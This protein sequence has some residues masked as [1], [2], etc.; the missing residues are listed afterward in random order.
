MASLNTELALVKRFHMLSKNYDNRPV[1]ARRNTLPSLVRFV[2]SKDRETRQYALAALHLLAQ[3]PENVELLAEQNGLVKE[4]FKVYKDTEYDDPELHDLSNELLNCLEPVLLGRDPRKETTSTAVVGS[5]GSG[6]GGGGGDGSSLNESTMNDSF[7]M[8]RRARA[9]RV[10]RGVGSDVIHTVILDIPAL[11]PQSGD[12]LATIEDIFQT[13]RGVVSY[14]V[15]LENRQARLFITCDTRAVQQVLSDAGF[16]SIVVRDEV[17]GQ[18]V[19]GGDTSSLNANNNNSNNNNTRSYYDSGP[20]KRQPTYFESL[21]NSIYQT[22]LVLRGGGGGGVGSNSG[23]DTLSARVQQ[24][25]AR[26]Q[27]GNSTL[28][29]V[30][31]VLAKW[32]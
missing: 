21:T 1:I 16:E 14:S 10:L 15:F 3:H 23:N 6:G 18:D 32:W 11:D 7:T 8:A 26:E 2:G 24:Q 28:S 25:R 20:Q 12:D 9:A 30:T 5:S 29:Q 4:V 19:F 31:K 17:V 22:A 13:T 27:Q